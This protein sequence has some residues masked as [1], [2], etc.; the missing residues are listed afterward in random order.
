MNDI[1]FELFKIEAQVEYEQ[2]IEGKSQ[3]FKDGLETGI[4]FIYQYF[5]ARNRAVAK[6]METLKGK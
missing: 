1:N 2:L 6:D 3:D 4:E 5:L